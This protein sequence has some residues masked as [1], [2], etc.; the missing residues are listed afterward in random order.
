MVFQRVDREGFQRKHFA[1]DM[2][3]D[4]ALPFNHVASLDMVLVFQPQ[5]GPLADDRIGEGKPGAITRQ[6]QTP[7]GPARPLD[8]AFPAQ[9][10]VQ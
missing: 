1:A 5:L 9:N 6:K 2:V 10:V 7:A 3:G 8:I 4:V